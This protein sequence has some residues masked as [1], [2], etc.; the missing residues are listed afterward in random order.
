MMWDAD[1]AYSEYSP[2]ILH[3]E[4]TFTFHIA[5]GRFD[6]AVKGAIVSSA[7][8]IAPQ[9]GKSSSAHAPSTVKASSASDHVPSTVKA[10]SSVNFPKPTATVTATP[11]IP[12]PTQSFVFRP[13]SP[14]QTEDAVASADRERFE[15]T[16]SA[17]KSFFTPSTTG[18]K[19][20]SNS[21]FFRL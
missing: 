6:K 20:R 2:S 21:R 9:V 13:F 10:T 14:H 11:D 17:D 1:T 8:K 3:S 7:A 5:N 16:A 4:I 12:S 15:K 18:A 19:K